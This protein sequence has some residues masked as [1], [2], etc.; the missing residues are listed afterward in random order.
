[1]EYKVAKSMKYQDV[2]MLY[3]SCALALLTMALVL[4]GCTT[5][6]TKKEEPKDLV[7]PSP[8]EQ[9]RIRYLKSYRGQSDFRPQDDFKARLLGAE[10][11]GLFLEKPYGV[12][13]NADSSRMYV[14]DSKLKK[15]VV[16]DFAAGQV[17]IMR[18]DAVGSMK[19]P[20]EVRVDKRGRVYVTDGY[21]GKLF[22]FG[23]D[24]K[25][26]LTLGKE[27]EMQRP[28]GLALDEAR[29]R[30]YVSDTPSHRIMIYDL[31]G[32]YVGEIGERGADPGQ[33]NYPVNLSVDREGR[34][35]VVDTGNF[36]VQVFSPEGDY[37]LEFGGIGDAWGSF[38]RPKGVGTDSEGHVYVLDAAFN[39]FQ[40]FDGSDGSLLLFVG[41]LGR[42]PG[43]FWLP[44]G[45]YID[46][47]DRIYV[48]DSIN[49][50]IQVFQYV[51]EDGDQ[52][53][54]KEEKVEKGE[55]TP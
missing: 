42:E 49:A 46:D 37:L 44:T 7:W 10:Q 32:G 22:V 55:K 36:R 50:R 40:V 38:S 53:A 26:L 19:S 33:F 18:T 29:N 16:F 25:T 15:V 17:S 12:A 35:Y 24:G 45:L 27:Q 54:E 39:N 3:R 47:G 4:V 1:M 6:E 34:L 30:L 20:V 48:A 31:E 2:G 23:P 43:M 5:P 14:T 28:T 9:P 8:P 21:G 41:Q 11:G 52:K 13:L 51:T